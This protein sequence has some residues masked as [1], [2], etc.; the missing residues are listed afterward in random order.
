M[1]SLDLAQDT[2]AAELLPTTEIAH[3]GCLPYRKFVVAN[4]PNTH[5]ITVSNDGN[6]FLQQLWETEQRDGSGTKL[7]WENSLS[8]NIYS[9]I[10]PSF[11]PDG[12][13]AVVPDGM[14]SVFKLDTQASLSSNAVKVPLPSMA[15]F[16]RRKLIDIAISCDGKRL[17]FLIDA[18]ERFD[19]GFGSIPYNDFSL[20][21]IVQSNGSMGIR[22]SFDSAKLFLAERIY[23]TRTGAGWTAGGMT[24]FD[25]RTAKH[26][27]SRSTELGFHLDT[28]RVLPGLVMHYSQPLIAINFMEPRRITYMLMNTLLPMKLHPKYLPPDRKLNRRIWLCPR[29]IVIRIA[30]RDQVIISDGKVLIFGK[31]GVKVWDGD[32]H[33]Y[34]HPTF[35]QFILDPEEEIVACTKEKIVTILKDG[36]FSTLNS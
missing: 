13:F 29:M 21:V 24:T 26:L 19:D 27:S 7:L 34:P 8:S 15:S 11:S 20:D 14:L 23:E 35:G 4:P 33:T 36:R 6:I 22:Y 1:S 18:T 30:D 17:G 10:Q 2:T 3:L 12:R 16:P 5:F 32:N 9:E 28:F 31:D 25:L